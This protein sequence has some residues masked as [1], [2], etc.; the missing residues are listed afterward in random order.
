M[1]CPRNANGK[2]KRA[3][4]RGKRA[5]PAIPTINAPPLHELDPS[6]R[7]LSENAGALN[8]AI[9]ALCYGDE[10]KATDEEC[11]NG[12]VYGK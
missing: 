8:S 5:S 6:S 1:R 4:T 2:K 10:T 9:D 3:L 11:W 12:Q 7:C